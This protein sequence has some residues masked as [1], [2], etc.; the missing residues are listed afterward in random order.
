MKSRHHDNCYLFILLIIKIKELEIYEQ[1][2]KK[3]IGI[4]K[5]HTHEKFDCTKLSL[6]WQAVYF[7]EQSTYFTARNMYRNEVGQLLWHTLL[8]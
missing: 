3:K 7:T 8:A 4:E 2:K 6:A 5:N 1:K